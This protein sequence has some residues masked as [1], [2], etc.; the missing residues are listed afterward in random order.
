[1][2]PVFATL[3][4]AGT[5]VL[6]METTS[7]ESCDVIMNMM[8]E[9]TTAAYED[10]DTERQLMNGMFPINAWDATCETERLEIDLRYRAEDYR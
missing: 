2:D 7:P 6:V 9:D 5:V 3:W 4:Y 10:N 8:L 1:M